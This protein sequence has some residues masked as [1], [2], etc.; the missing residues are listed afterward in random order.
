MCKCTPYAA[1]LSGLILHRAILVTLS[2]SPTLASKSEY[3][4]LEAVLSEIKSFKA[5]AASWYD[6]NRKSAIDAAL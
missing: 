3:R 6:K 1:I 4:A 5:P 2:P